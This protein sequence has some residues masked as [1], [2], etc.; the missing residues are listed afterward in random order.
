M[1]TIHKYF[2]LYKYITIFVPGH[3]EI[4]NK[5][6]SVSSSDASHWTFIHIA[7]FGGCRELVEF[8]WKTLRLVAVIL[9][10]YGFLCLLQWRHNERDG[11]SDHQ[12]H[13]YLLN[14][15]FRHRSK[16]TSKLRVT[17]LC[18]GNSPVTSGF[19]AQKASNAENDSIWWRH[20]DAIICP[21]PSE[22]VTHWYQNCTVI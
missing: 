20:H 4:I 8:N 19:P 13:D 22:H 7:L 16:K 17:G 2:L 11:V 21:M 3:F 14:L 1:R 15:L 12:P 10:I 18:A 5:W 6:V 9:D